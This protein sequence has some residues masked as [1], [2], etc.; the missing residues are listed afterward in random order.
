MALTFTV[1]YSTVCIL[2]LISFIKN[3]TSL[4]FHIQ[5]GERKCFIEE[6]PD[7]TLVVGE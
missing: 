4:Y 7:D 2:I 1:K 5:E 6:I 3:T